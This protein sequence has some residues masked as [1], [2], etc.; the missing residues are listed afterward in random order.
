VVEERCL[1]RQSERILRLIADG[2]TFAQI[3]RSEPGLKPVD[4]S[5]AAAE[6][7]QVFGPVLEP[8]TRL[9]EVR[10]EVPRVYARWSENEDRL[11]TELHRRGV[12][13]KNIAV[14]L[15]RSELGVKARLVKMGLL[16]ESDVPELKELQARRRRRRH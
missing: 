11:L 14:K 10:R 15:Q 2:R 5:D 16:S 3:L 13:P 7:L 8:R 1:S 12:L 6:V 4:I 9:E